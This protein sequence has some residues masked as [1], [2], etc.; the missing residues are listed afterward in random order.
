MGKER[1]GGKSALKLSGKSSS[2]FSEESCKFFHL[3]FF[4]SAAGAEALEQLSADVLGIAAAAA[5]SGDKKGSVLTVA[6]DRGANQLFKS[7]QTHGKLRKPFGQVSKYC[8]LIFHNFLKL[9]RNELF[10]TSVYK[11]DFPV[12]GQG[13]RLVIQDGFQSVGGTPHLFKGGDNGGGV[14]IFQ[15]VFQFSAVV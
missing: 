4:E 15:S 9:F 11:E 3:L 12:L 8:L 6:L 10:L 2:L 7:R 13:P 5:V 14:V 1:N